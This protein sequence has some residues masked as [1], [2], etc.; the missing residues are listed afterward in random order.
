LRQSLGEF[1]QTLS[2]KL[3]GGLLTRFEYR[4]DESNAK[5]F[6]GNQVTITPAAGV[7]NAA[8]LA[9]QDTFSG[10]AIFVY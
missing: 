2:Y 3:T 6:F 1:T 9:G 10:S 8:T 7:V 4:H 5:P